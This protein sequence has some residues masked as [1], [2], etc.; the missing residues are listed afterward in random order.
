A[1]IGEL[2]TAA[3]PMGG[4]L[5]RDSGARALRQSLAALGSEVI[6]PQAGP[7]AP[8][9]LSDLGLALQRDGT[10]QLDNQRLQATLTRDPAGAAAMF[11]AGLYGIF[12]TGDRIA[13]S[14]TGSG[15]ANSLT[16]SLSRYEKLSA[17]VTKDTATLAEKQEALRA[18]L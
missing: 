5:A 13:R 1:V 11:T 4:D 2:N 8:R 15:S 16:N 12:A 14:A 9:T 7:G 10:F 17:Q 6:M 3:N 18:T